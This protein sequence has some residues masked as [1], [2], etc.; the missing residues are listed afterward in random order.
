MIA[1]D[2]EILDGGRGELTLADAGG[3]VTAREAGALLEVEAAAAAT[4]C[5]IEEGPH[6]AVA[7]A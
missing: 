7:A 3:R 2:L 5:R 1:T 6:V 4:E